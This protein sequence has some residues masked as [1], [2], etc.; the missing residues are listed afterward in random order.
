MRSSKGFILAAGPKLRKTQR[1]GGKN[2]HSNS[3]SLKIF[4]PLALLILTSDWPNVISKY[5]SEHSF[6]KTRKGEKL[7]KYG[8]NMAALEVTFERQHRNAEALTVERL[9]VSI[10][11]F[12]LS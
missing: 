6:S 3:L 4:S 2:Q 10:S 1:D 8:A 12:I 11:Y 9:L 7:P 5:C